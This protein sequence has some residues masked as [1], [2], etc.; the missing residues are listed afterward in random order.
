MPVAAAAAAR[1]AGTGAG[2]GTGGGTG[3]SRAES[4]EPACGPHSVVAAASELAGPRRPA[5][6]ATVG[7]GPAWHPAPR[8]RL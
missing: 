4:A 5:S 8:G 3:C 6:A 7:P 2:H 1:G